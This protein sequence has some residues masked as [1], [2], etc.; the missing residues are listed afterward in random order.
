MVLY[1][2]CV[3]SCNKH[4]SSWVARYIHACANETHSIANLQ[5]LIL[6]LAAIIIYKQHKLAKV[7][8]KSCRFAIECV[9]FVH[10]WM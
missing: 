10:A 5:D 2:I 3:C 6:T 8:I 9:S 1:G 4:N 7:R